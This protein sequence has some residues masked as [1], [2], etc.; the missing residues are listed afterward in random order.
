MT[1]DLVIFI[2]MLKTPGQPLNILK[3]TN[4]IQMLNVKNV[5]KFLKHKK[6][7]KINKLVYSNMFQMW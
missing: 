5:Q 7:G 6:K 4:G 3:L 2:C 1:I